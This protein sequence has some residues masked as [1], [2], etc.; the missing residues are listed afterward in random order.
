MYDFSQNISRC[1]NIIG[2][3]FKDKKNCCEAL[4]AAGALPGLP[5]NRSIAI[6]G[7]TASE[8]HLCLL[9][10]E[11]GLSKGQWQL[12][13]PLAFHAMGRTNIAQ[14]SWTTIRKEV[15]GNRNLTDVGS[16][17]GLDKC[18]ILNPGTSTTSP[19]M[20]ATAVEAILGAVRRDGGEDKMAAVMVRLG[21]NKH[22]LLPLVTFLL[23]PL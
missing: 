14:G 18:L 9:W 1:E 7:D 6:L 4:N 20:I 13:S 10:I 17:H 5:N 3:E 15:L 22:A 23:P 19:N 21:L 8:T 16:R 12:A 2:Y 11:S